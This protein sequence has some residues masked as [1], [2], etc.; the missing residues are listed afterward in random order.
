MNKIFDFK[1]LRIFETAIHR[2]KNF[3]PRQGEIVK[4]GNKSY[5]ILHSIED[6]EE[7]WYT[8]KHR[9]IEHVWISHKIVVTDDSELIKKSI[10]KDENTKKFIKDTV[11][12]HFDQF[13]QD[14]LYIPITVKSKNQEQFFKEFHGKY[15]TSDEIISNEQNVYPNEF[16]ISSGAI[17]QDPHIDSKSYLDDLELNSLNIFYSSEDNLSWMATFY[18][19]DFYVQN[20]GKQDHK[21]SFNIIYKGGSY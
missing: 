11:L 5:V 20:I 15:K 14:Y 19:G 13:L 3:E 6:N 9:N 8:E 12:E 21:D 17:I 10:K 2:S 7:N 18:V 1:N 16:F 4:I